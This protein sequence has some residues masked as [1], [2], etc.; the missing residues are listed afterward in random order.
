MPSPDE[1]LRRAVGDNDVAA[2][3]AALA[4]GAD[5]NARA[6]YG[7]TAL[8]VAAG[9]GERGIVERLLDAGAD[10]ENR[11]GADLTPL[12]NAAL[13][14][15]VDVTR[16]LLDRGARVDRGL[17]SSL[18][19]KVGILEENAEAGMVLPSAAEAWRG[20]LEF[21]IGKWKEQNPED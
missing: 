15:H 17:L 7:D 10:I 6:E 21:L 5:P 11:G 19:M 3:E 18:Q 16:L 8:N 13:G 1:A 14:G 2:V 9:S 4:A 12:M 20:F